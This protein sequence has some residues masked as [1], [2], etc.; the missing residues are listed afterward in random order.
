MHSRHQTTITEHNMKPHHYSLTKTTIQ[1]AYEQ[2]I[3]SQKLKEITTEDTKN[4]ECESPKG[5]QNTGRSDTIFS[6]HKR[7]RYKD[8][9]KS[10]TQE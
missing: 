9:R 10:T 5:N 4:K 8:E 6:D 2:K 1:T 3:Q 7:M